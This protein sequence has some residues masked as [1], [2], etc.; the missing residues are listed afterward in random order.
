M[1]SCYAGERNNSNLN[2]KHVRLTIKVRIRESE[3]GHPTFRKCTHNFISKHNRRHEYM[4]L[5]GNKLSFATESF[6]ALV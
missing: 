1:S 4:S 5:L 3:A 2:Y 6:D